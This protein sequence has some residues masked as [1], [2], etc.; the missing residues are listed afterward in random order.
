MILAAGVVTNV[1]NQPAA[2]RAAGA[3]PSVAKRLGEMENE[4]FP[5]A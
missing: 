1:H 4:T 5:K 2:R 3:T